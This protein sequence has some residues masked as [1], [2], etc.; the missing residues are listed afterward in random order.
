MDIYGVVNMDIVGSRKLSGDNRSKVQETI[1]N[2]MDCI[3]DEYSE[4]LIA[5][6]GFT[7]GDEW[8]LITKEPSQC[9]NLIHKFQQLL[10]KDE[11]DIYAGIGIGSISTR[12]YKD[13]REMDGECFI[14]ARKAI[15]LVKEKNSYNNNYITSKNNRVLFF[16][17][18]DKNNNFFYDSL[19]NQKSQI[20]WE[21]EVALTNVYNTSYWG[22]SY[23]HLNLF[24]LINI[25]IENTE[26]L[27]SRMTTKQKQTYVDYLKLG[28]YRK[29]IKESSSNNHREST[30]SISQKINKAEFFTIQR[31]HE[32]VEQLLRYYSELGR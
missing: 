14:N 29:V 18:V 24:N 22:D 6:I 21:D 1:K 28:S 2:Y 19:R 25:I 3:Y 26:I 5:P 10:W 11:I 7:L 17:D 13:T 4:I 12:I 23:K 32:M 15:K 30:S 31:N 8:Q 16:T 27:K 20:G 9:Y